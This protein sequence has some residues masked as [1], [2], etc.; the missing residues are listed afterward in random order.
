M[1]MSAATMISTAVL[2]LLAVSTSVQAQE[3]LSGIK[4]AQP[5][6]VDPGPPGGPPSDAV[7]LFDG[8]DMSQWLNAEKWEVKEGAMISGPGAV[9]SKAEFGDCQ[10]HIEFATDTVI[11][12]DGQG[13]SNSGVFLMGTYELQ[14]LDSYQNETYFDGQCGSH[15]QTASSPG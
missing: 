8:K 6:V 10:V 7:V 5:A 3:Y 13:R 12:G 4:W 11:S 14:V 15:L 1:K 9:R 2:V